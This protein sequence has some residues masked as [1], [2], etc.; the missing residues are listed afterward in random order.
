[1]EFIENQLIRWFG[2]NVN[3]ALQVLMV[4][5]FILLISVSVVI[6]VFNLIADP[7][8]AS[9]ASWGFMN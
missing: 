8:V 7:S 5:F 6:A 3:T 4:A 1:M 2:M 9:N